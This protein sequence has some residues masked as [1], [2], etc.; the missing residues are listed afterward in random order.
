MNDINKKLIDKNRE[1]EN[2]RHKLQT[3]NSTN[4]A[5]TKEHDNIIDEDEK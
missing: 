1:I 3:K 4:D 2:L 5:E